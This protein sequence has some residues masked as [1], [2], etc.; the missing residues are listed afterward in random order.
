MKTRRGEILEIS[1]NSRN[2]IK[3]CK[4]LQTKVAPIEHFE[5]I[6]NVNFRLHLKYYK[7]KGNLIS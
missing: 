2:N 3:M 1:T 4:F 7:I 5:Q 6:S